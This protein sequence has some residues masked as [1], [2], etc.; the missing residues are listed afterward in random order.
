MVIIQNLGTEAI[1]E[2]RKHEKPHWVL[3]SK[4]MIGRNK[5]YEHQQKLAKEENNNV[6]GTK[7]SGL[8]DTAISVFMEYVRSGERN[9]IW[10]SAKNEYNMVRVNEQTNGGRLGLG[11]APSGLDVYP[12]SMAVPMRAS[13]LLSPGSPLAFE[14]L[15][16]G[17]SLDFL[18]IVP[19][20]YTIF[21]FT[22]CPCFFQF[23]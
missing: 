14:N 9:F 22:L 21:F 20:E 18:F 19:F 16:L 11:F 15:T 4:E 23:I 5:S 7:I 6:P 10:D 17:K 13:V 1:Q 8:I 3:I 2:K 12:S